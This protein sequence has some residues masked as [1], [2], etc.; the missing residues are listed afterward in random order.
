MT[1]EPMYF[2]QVKG[3]M[4]AEAVADTLEEAG[5][6]SANNVLIVDEQVQPMQRD[7][8]LF[9]LEEMARTLDVAD[10]MNI[11]WE[12]VYADDDTEE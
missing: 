7:E 2:I 4:E 6:E 5:V 1:A 11:D 3:A 8:V 12:E 10:E 9:F